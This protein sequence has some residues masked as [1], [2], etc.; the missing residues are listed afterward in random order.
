MRNAALLACFLLLAEAAALAK[1]KLKELPARSAKEYPA[2]QDFQKIVMGAY[3]CETQE[4]ALELF[5]TPKLFEKKIMPVLMVVENNNDFGIRLHEKD[6]FLIDAEGTH[7]QAISYVDVLLQ[8]SLKKLPSSYSTKRELMIRAV[9]NK[10]M[11]QDFE[12]KAFGE[13]LIAPKS[14][15]RGV[16]FFR[17][18]EGGDLSGTRLYF[19]NVWNLSEE[20]QLIFFE[21]ELGRTEQ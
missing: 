16:V 8:I 11:V 19:P 13:K 4:K 6:I 3:P 10:D 20:T 5:D 9:G 12:H 14:S 21:F 7:H 15:D 17:L 1:Y 2:H 18:P